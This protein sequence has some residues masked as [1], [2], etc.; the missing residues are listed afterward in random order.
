[1]DNLYT[2]VTKNRIEAQHP[3]HTNPSLNPVF[4]KRLNYATSILRED[5][6]ETI[7]MNRW[8]FENCSGKWG[9]YFLWVDNLSR[10]YFFTNKDDAVHFKLVWVQES[11]N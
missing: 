10:V 1:M 11:I 4:V 5:S 9:T 8:C 2:T 6:S 7:K 3:I